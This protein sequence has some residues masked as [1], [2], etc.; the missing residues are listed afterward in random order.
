[1]PKGNHAV[2]DAH[3]RKDWQRRVRTWFD[4]PASAQK[5]RHARALKVILDFP[6]L[7]QIPLPFT[8]SRHILII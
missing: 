1:M 4:Q 2:G 7:I 6:I 5:R 3:F 8:H